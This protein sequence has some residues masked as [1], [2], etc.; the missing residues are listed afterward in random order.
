MWIS[1]P[2]AIDDDEDKVEPNAAPHTSKLSDLEAMAHDYQAAIGVDYPEALRRAELLLTS[3][4]TIAS[5]REVAAGTLAGLAIEHEPDLTIQLRLTDAPS[6]ALLSIIADSPIPIIV[7][8]APRLSLA[9][10]RQRIAAIEIGAAMP[11]VQGHG[12]D[13]RTGELVIDVF[14]EEGTGKADTL[15]DI[16]VAQIALSEQLGMPIRIEYHSAPVRLHGG[17]GTDGD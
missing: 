11:G 4:E 1:S 17:D 8:F 14:V 6:E 13:E 10:S 15:A 3:D 9:E 12:F 16:A 7:D 5:I 2:N